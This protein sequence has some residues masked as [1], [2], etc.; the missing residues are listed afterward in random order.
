MEGE[1][2]LPLEYVDPEDR[3][4]DL[5]DMHIRCL[6]SNEAPK[7]WSVADNGIFIDVDTAYP[8][9]LVNE[10]YQ[11]GDPAGI[12]DPFKRILSFGRRVRIG[13]SIIANVFEL[14]TKYDYSDWW[15]WISA[16]PSARKSSE[17]GWVR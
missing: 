14:D 13:G 10:R 7:I 12:D 4:L 17:V 15:F 9:E 3:R 8:V 16:G 1:N 6:R 2:R 5:R 11:I